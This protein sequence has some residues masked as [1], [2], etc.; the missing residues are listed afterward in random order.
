MAAQWVTAFTE[1]FEDAGSL[2]GQSRSRQNPRHHGSILGFEG[3]MFLFGSLLGAATPCSPARHLGGHRRR[4]CR[5]ASAM[6]GWGFRS[7]ERDPGG[8]RVPARGGSAARVPS[9]SSIARDPGPPPRRLRG[10]SFA[11]SHAAGFSSPLRSRGDCGSSSRPASSTSPWRSR[12]TSRRPP[13]TAR[14]RSP[15]RP[16]GGCR[17]RLPSSSS[18]QRPA[19]PGPAKRRRSTGSPQPVRCHKVSRREG[20]SS[21]RVADGVGMSGSGAGSSGESVAGER[22]P[23]AEDAQSCSSNRLLAGR[24]EERPPPAVPLSDR[25]EH[26]DALVVGCLVSLYSVLAMACGDDYDAPCSLGGHQT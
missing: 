1:G 15:L 25:A 10:D 19:S 14:P 12:G 20:G 7:C 22:L 9:Q 23:P 6:R 17:Q 2:G 13:T 5:V 11:S 8:G 18:G 21:G 16:R 24:G 26:L 4:C 3:D